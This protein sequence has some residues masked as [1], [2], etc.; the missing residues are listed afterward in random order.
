[1]WVHSRAR[2]KPKR[3]TLKLPL[4]RR[5]AKRLVHKVAAMEKAVFSL[6]GFDG[7]QI[8]T[9]IHR[10]ENQG[11]YP[12]IVVAEG[13]PLAL[14]VGRLDDKIND[15][16]QLHEIPIVAERPFDE[17]TSSK[18]RRLAWWLLTSCSPMTIW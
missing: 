17:Q 13:E 6:T 16:K 4:R 5:L 10:L 18:S 3:S 12:S 15:L 7:D 14:R 2:I 9:R 1:M 8:L 11:L